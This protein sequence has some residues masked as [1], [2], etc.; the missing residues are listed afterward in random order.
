MPP[1][2]EDLREHGG[3]STLSQYFHVHPPTS[4]KRIG[5][6]ASSTRLR[7]H[8][9]N[10]KIWTAFLLVVPNLTSCRKEI[11]VRPHFLEFE[12]QL[13][14]SLRQM[15][16]G[17]SLDTSVPDEAVRKNLRQLYDACSRAPEHVDAKYELYCQEAQSQLSVLME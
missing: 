11:D 5:N 2:L 16:D 1:G 14:D 15:L 9:Q 6:I 13:R 7:R 8:V 3:A 17:P 4:I 12:Y 10:L